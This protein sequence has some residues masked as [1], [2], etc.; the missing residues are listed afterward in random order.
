MMRARSDLMESLGM[1]WPRCGM[2]DGCR[3]PVRARGDLVMG[4][5]LKRHIDRL[6]LCRG[7]SLWWF[8]VT[9]EPLSPRKYQSTQKG[10]RSL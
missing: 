2:W 3:Q 5:R 7:L 6:W 10:G 1:A 8:G 4:S 9:K